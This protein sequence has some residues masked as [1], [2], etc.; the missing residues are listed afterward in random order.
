MRFWSA[1]LM[2]DVSISGSVKKMKDKNKCEFTGS[3]EEAIAQGY[4]P[5]QRCIGK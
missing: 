1:Y 4:S 3:R 2:H 5:C